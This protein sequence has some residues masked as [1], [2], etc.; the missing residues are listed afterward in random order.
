M[1][2]ILA[3]AQPSIADAWIRMIKKVLERSEFLE[4]WIPEIGV[5]SADEFT[6]MSFFDIPGMRLIRGGTCFGEEI[7]SE[8]AS[9]E[10]AR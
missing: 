8:N 6:I 5:K 7:R 4:C 2:F 3:G 9:I 10:C 1:V